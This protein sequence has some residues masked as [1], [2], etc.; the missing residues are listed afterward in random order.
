MYNKTINFITNSDSIP[1]IPGQAHEKTM[2]KLTV[3]DD[4]V[5]MEGAEWIQMF[6][7]VEGS[8]VDRLV[9]DIIA[10]MGFNGLTAVYDK[11]AA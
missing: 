2:Y 5:E 4:A 1:A 8:S 11:R 9:S 3:Y 7:P 10:D 6:R